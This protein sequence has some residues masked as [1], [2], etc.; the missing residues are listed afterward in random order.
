MEDQQ[1]RLLD[2]ALRFLGYRPRSQK[3]ITDFLGKKTS[4]LT[5]INQTIE[6]LE[7]LKL[8][9]D[10]DFADWLVKSRSRNRGSIFIKQDL[11]KRGIDTASMD[12][13]VNDQQTAISLLQKKAISWSKLSYRDFYQKAFRYL[14]Y[15][16]F[17]SSI[18]AQ[19][20]KKVYNNDYV[21]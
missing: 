21:S 13:S 5:L 3:E 16:G 9:S 7:K 20:V 8:I 4:D 10:S 12:L 17:P 6:K 14:G 15:R 19:A 1:K 2:S 11:K 18:I